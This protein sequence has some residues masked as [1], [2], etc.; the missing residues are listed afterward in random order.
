MIQIS[1]DLRK[2]TKEIS[3]I[4]QDQKI[5]IYEEFKENNSIVE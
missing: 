1:Q 4:Y 3:E 5:T 2:K